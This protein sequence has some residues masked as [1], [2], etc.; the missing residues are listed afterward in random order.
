FFHA[1]GK[2]QQL[3]F[4]Q[5]YQLDKKASQKAND[6][7]GN[8]VLRP[9]GV[10]PFASRLLN[11][12][13]KKPRVAV[14]VAEAVLGQESG[15]FILSLRGMK[16]ALAQH[17]IQSHDIVIKKQAGGGRFEAA[18][19]THEESRYEDLEDDIRELDDDLKR[20]EKVVGIRKEQHD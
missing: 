11:V 13:E 17:G 12:D 4:T 9:Q 10:E 3:S 6:G 7:K 19:L 1:R 20:Q 8:L 15:H 16:K 5:V 18:A 14:A 2:V